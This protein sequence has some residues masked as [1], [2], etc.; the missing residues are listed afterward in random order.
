MDVIHCVQCCVAQKQDDAIN[1]F[2][3]PKIDIA[4]LSNAL[5]CVMSGVE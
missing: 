4:G 3:L 5:H 2:M 1:V